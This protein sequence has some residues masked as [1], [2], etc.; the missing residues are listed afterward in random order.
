M[1]NWLALG[2]GEQEKLLCQ[3][4]CKSENDLQLDDFNYHVKIHHLDVKRK[5]LERY[6][7]IS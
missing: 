3:N 6:E 1:I 5:F 4:L 2:G 7:Y